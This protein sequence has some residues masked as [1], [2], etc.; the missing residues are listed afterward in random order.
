MLHSITYVWGA[1]AD[2]LLY[3]MCVVCYDALLVSLLS[4]DHQP[5]IRDR[6]QT[7]NAINIHTSDATSI[8]HMIYVL[9]TK[10]RHFT[11]ILHLDVIRGFLRFQ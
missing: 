1:C 4:F 2:I 5:L 3:G 10:T 9:E 7:S 11:D 6:A 8:I